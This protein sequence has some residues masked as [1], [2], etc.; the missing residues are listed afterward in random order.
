MQF[1]PGMYPDMDIEQYHSAPGIS[2][3]GINKI[4]D[5][6]ARYHYEYIV[7]REKRNEKDIKQEAE[8]FKLGRALHTRLLEP[9]KFDSLF[10]LF[11]PPN[12][13][14][15]KTKQEKAAHPNSNV[16]KDAYMNFLS[17]G[18]YALDKL[19]Y[20]N[21]NAMADAAAGHAIWNLIKD[22]HCEHSFFWH[23]GL[24][25][26]P[27]RARP[28]IYNDRI[29]IDVKTTRNIRTWPKSIIEYGYHRQA[30]MQRDALERYDGRRRYFGF[31]VIETVPPYLCRAFTLS[32]LYMALGRREYLDG[33]NTYSECLM[34]NAWPGYEDNFELIDA[35][36]WALEGKI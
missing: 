6:P 1:E 35:P 31:F 8:H 25:K 22:G 24:Y 9:H 3:S 16:Y 12:V 29:I 18:K 10:G 4:L 23:D 19:E 26:T 33:A 21:V 28:D 15:E 32:E 20:D 2:S 13:V 5:C 34:A 17:S 11:I 30:A 36:K 14:D 7:C 27:L